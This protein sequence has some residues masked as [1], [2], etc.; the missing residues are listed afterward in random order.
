MPSRG[1]CRENVLLIGDNSELRDTREDPG[2]ATWGEMV[3][4]LTRVRAVKVVRSGGESGR[5]H[6]TFLIGEK[7]FIRAKGDQACS[8]HGPLLDRPTL[9]CQSPRPTF[10]DA[11]GFQLG[12]LVK[13]LG[14][15]PSA[16]H[17]HPCTYVHIWYESPLVCPGSEA[18]PPGPRLILDHLSWLH[19]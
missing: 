5:V 16:L 11:C 17:T 3:A 6:I 18:G 10:G 19:P 8:P 14:V 1:C 2:Q 13:L 9:A 7:L 4:A 15:V 12:H